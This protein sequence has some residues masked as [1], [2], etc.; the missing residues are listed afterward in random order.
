MNFLP[1]VEVVC[2]V[3][4]GRRYQKSVLHVK[5]REHSISD[6]LDLSVDEAAVLLKNQRNIMEK[7]QLLQDVGLGYLGLVIHH[8]LDGICLLL[9]GH[10]ILRMDGEAARH[11]P[12]NHWS[13]NRTCFRNVKYSAF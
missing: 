3:C 8:L 13:G 9:I 10:G 1:D 12:Q 11:F 6:I 7:L 5:Y 4:R 2:P